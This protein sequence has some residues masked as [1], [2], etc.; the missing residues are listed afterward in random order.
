MRI[1]PQEFYARPARIVASDLLGKRLVRKW[2]GQRIAG[3][4]VESEA[5]CDADEPDLACHGDRANDGRPTP[6]TE[7][8][9]GPAGYSYVYFTYGMHWM[10]NIVTG[11]KGQ[12]NAVLIRALEPV[13]GEGLMAQNRA[14][15]EQAIWTNGPAK[16]T[17]A[18]AIDGNLNGAC[19]FTRDG[20]VWIENEPAVSADNISKGPRVGLGNTPEPWLSKP[21]RYWLNGNK[22]VSGK[23]YR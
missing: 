7:V 21:W 17:Q 22:Y 2:N 6:R 4:I 18:L 13:E 11:E 14:G 3:F 9:F 5:Y 8:M 20:E 16:L 12:A 10:F 19:L 23:N 15:R 1:L